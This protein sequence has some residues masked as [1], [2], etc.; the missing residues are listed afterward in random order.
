MKLLST[1]LPVGK[2]LESLEDRLRAR[3]LLESQ[4][5]ALDAR[6]QV[7]PR[8]DPLA[9]NLRALESHADPTEPLPLYTHRG[10]LGGAAVLWTKRL[11]RKSCQLLI[12]ETLGRQRL[13]NGHVRDAYAQLAAEV[14][15]LRQ[16][17]QER[18]VSARKRA[19]TPP[20]RAAPRPAKPKKKRS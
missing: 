1:D 10:G 11:F 9:F 2:L 8:V 7:E 15:A 3:G 12:N 14:T 20:R 6:P 16:Q 17:L 19:R 4:P 18:P 13:F 5:S